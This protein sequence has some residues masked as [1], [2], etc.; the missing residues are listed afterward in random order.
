MRNVVMDL[1]NYN[2]K[3]LS[4]SKGIFSSKNTTKFNSNAE[5]FE[6]IK[7]DGQATYIGTGQLDAEYNKVNKSYIS[8]LL[9]NITKATNESDINL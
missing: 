2:I 1:G 8:S 5:M 4:E 6:I 3:Y 9:Y 7:Y